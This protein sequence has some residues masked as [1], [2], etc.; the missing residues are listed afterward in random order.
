MDP[1]NAQAVVQITLGQVYSEVTGMRADLRDLTSTMK[2]AVG[3]LGDHENRLRTVEHDYV[4]SAE[5]DRV[6]TVASTELEK[7]VGRV[8]ALERWR[9]TVTP[10]VGALSAGVGAAVAKAVGH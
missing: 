1:G 8:G 10:L 2:T 4:T 6:K 9:W 3:Q 5:L 7:L